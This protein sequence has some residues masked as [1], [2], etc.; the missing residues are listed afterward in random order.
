[1]FAPFLSS[2]RLF[3]LSVNSGMGAV[4]REPRRK[5]QQKSY[6]WGYRTSG[7]AR[8]PVVLYDYQPS[9]AGEC[10][11][12][13]LSGFSGFLHTGGYEAYH[14]KLPPE[15]TTVGCWAHMRRKFTDALKSLPK[16]IRD[17]SPAQVGLEFCNELFGLE[18]DYAK[19]KLSFEQRQLARIERSKPVAEG[20]FAWAKKEYDR[21]PVPKSIFGAALTYAVRQESW[22]MNVFLDERL[23][24][25]NNRAER[26]VRPFALGRKNWLFSNTPRGADASATIYSIVESAK[27]NA[28]KPFDYLAFL[29]EHLPLGRSIDDCLLWSPLARSL[30]V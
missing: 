26:S 9:R 21:N 18:E 29:L 13:F 17:R 24:L 22:L 1:M 8:R 25:S 12:N 19:Q 5:A 3:F 4:L 23:E 30:C 28:L 2:L 7:D 27:A 16:D 11:S 10:A 15:I 14:C 20:F 6:V